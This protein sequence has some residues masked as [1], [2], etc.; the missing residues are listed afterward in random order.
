M[1]VDDRELQ[2]NN[3]LVIDRWLQFNNMLVVDGVL[4]FNNMPVEQ[5]DKGRG[6]EG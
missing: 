5:I 4:Q 1:P 6:Y 2:F 3:M